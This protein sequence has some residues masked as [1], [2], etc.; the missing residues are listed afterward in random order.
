MKLCA[1]LL[2]LG[3]TSSSFADYFNCGGSSGYG[4]FFHNSDF[5]NERA[6]NYSVG[7]PYGFNYYANNADQAWAS[8]LGRI[9]ADYNSAHRS[10]ASLPGKYQIKY[11]FS[12][13]ELRSGYR[14]LRRVSYNNLYAPCNAKP[15]F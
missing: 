10:C 6:P 3:F 15:L 9:Q 14:V 13:G 7:S 8:C 2:I 5:Q 12:Y 4:A 1:L 11:A